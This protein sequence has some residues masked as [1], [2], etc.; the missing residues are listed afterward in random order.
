MPAANTVQIRNQDIAGLC[1]RIKKFRF[2]MTESQSAGL[3]SFRVFD[4]TRMKHY[5][6]TLRTY[7]AWVM[8]QPELDLP[9][10]HP[11][12]YNV[13]LPEAPVSAENTAV[14]DVVRLLDALV[15]ELSRSQSS[16]LATGLETFDAA[17]FDAIVTK[18]EK[19]LTDYVEVATPIDLPEGAAAGNTGSV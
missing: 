19:F 17:R 5:L 11:T 6:T 1:A 15:L 7:K 13:E 2:E 8:D 4:V 14:V 3:A 12:L 16:D 10:S 9:K 18:V